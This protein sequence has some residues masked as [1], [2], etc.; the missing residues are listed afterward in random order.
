MP[1][2]NTFLPFLDGF[3]VVT[4]KPDGNALRVDLT[5]H[6]T[7]FP[8]CG[9]CHKPC[10]TTHEYCERVV[11]DLPILGR[12]V[13]FNVFGAFAVVTM[14][15]EWKQSAGWIT[16]PA[17]PTCYPS[18]RAASNPALEH[19]ATTEASLFAGYF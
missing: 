12:P 14:A 17:W 11:R 5:P 10:S 2:T 9:G 8:A 1:D 18:L 6:A 3:S 16:M 7:R 15:N 13:R 19:R 4:I